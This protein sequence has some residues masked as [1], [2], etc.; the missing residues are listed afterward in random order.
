MDRNIWSFHLSSFD[1]VTFLLHPST[2]TRTINGAHDGLK[3]AKMCRLD[4]TICP[5]AFDIA[6]V[7]AYRGRSPNKT[8]DYKTDIVYLTSPISTK[9][10]TELIVFLLYRED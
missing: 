6:A 7:T 8:A 10:I 3:P 1:R 9:E 2:H 5:D 4:T